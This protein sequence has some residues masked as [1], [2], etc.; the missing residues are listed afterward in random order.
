MMLVCMCLGTRVYAEDNAWIGAFVHVYLSEYFYT[1]IWPNKHANTLKTSEK[2]SMSGVKVSYTAYLVNPLSLCHTSD[3]RKQPC[4]VFIVTYCRV[5][6]LLIAKAHKR[7]AHWVPLLWKKENAANKD[8]G[9]FCVNYKI[10]WLLYKNQ[11]EKM[12]LPVVNI[13]RKIK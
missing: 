7:N 12:Q 2:G 4:S 3:V 9:T 10:A 8:K 5:F 6:S 1:D 13:W 11:L